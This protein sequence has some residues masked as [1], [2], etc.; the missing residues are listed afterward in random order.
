MGIITIWKKF[1]FVT[2]WQY[3]FHKKNTFDSKIDFWTFF[4]LLQYSNKLTFFT[5][6]TDLILI[7]TSF[8]T[9]I[10]FFIKYIIFWEE[11]I[12]VHRIIKTVVYFLKYVG[13]E[14][15]TGRHCIMTY[16]LLI[17]I[18]SKSHYYNKKVVHVIVQI[19]KI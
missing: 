11:K 17:I 16:R 18:T 5:I 3:F 1:L 6:N 19:T 4:F 14:I 12:N 13:T 9:H 2:N 15:D 7:W 10:N 8:I